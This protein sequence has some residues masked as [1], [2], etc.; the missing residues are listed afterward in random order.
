MTDGYPA[1]K[2]AYDEVY[3]RTRGPGFGWIQWKGTDACIDVECLC[4]NVEH[5]DGFFQ[6]GWRCG[7][8]HRIYALDPIIQLLP[9]TD[10][11]AK[12]LGLTGME[13]SDEDI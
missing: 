12:S 11:Q 7:E 6:Y 4:G 5:L 8:C 3:K 2:A 13:T 1:Y 9:V 10:A